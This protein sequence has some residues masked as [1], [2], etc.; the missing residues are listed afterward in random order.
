M[1]STLKIS[2]QRGT[3]L[4][5]TAKESVSLQLQ[6]ELQLNS[7][8]KYP[9]NRILFLIDGRIEWFLN[10]HP[11]SETQNTILN[12]IPPNSP[13]MVMNLTQIPLSVTIDHNF[14]DLTSLFNPYLYEQEVHKKFDPDTFLDLFHIP[15]GYTDTLA[16][17][18]SVK[19]TYENYN[20]ILIR[21]GT[22][23]SFQSHRMRAEH[24][25]ILN[26]N[27]IIIAGTHVWYS[28]PQGTE[29]DLPLGA[30]HSIINPSPTDWVMFK[31]TYQG[32]FDED[33]IIRVF[34]PNHYFS[35]SQ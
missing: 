17:W 31:E 6:F 25:Q 35:S 5:V 21:P 18:Y 32:T 23:L 7:D 22:G 14:D 1:G 33:D 11:E 27:P 8:D 4:Y 20:L 28:N 16:K 26:G 10:F 13:F 30:L 24:W 34:N 12:V 29:R 15:Q 2:P 9:W 19:F 3:E